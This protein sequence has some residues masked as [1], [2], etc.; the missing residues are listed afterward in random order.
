M[1]TYL[2]T[3]HICIIFPTTPTTNT[4]GYQHRRTIGPSGTWLH[5]HHTRVV[6]PHIGTALR[7]PEKVLGD[8]VLNPLEPAVR[9]LDKAALGKVG[10][11]RLPWCCSAPL[12]LGGLRGRGWGVWG[13][14]T[15][16]CENKGDYYPKIDEIIQLQIIFKQEILQWKG[17]L[18]LKRLFSKYLAMIHRELIFLAYKL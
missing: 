4:E 11:M 3:R 18:Q 16:A 14:P 15:H 1:P 5:P 9:Q 10:G 13:C 17:S 2:N 12:G 7:G 6:N 8:Q